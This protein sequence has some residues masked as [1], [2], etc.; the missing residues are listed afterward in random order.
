M[1]VQ[2]LGWED[3]LVEGWQSTPV[4]LPGE[5]HGQRSL[6]GFIGS[7][8][9]GHDGSDLARVLNAYLLNMQAER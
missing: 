4:F 6:V 8:T 7:H 3:P 5:S 2:S 9:V 1:Q